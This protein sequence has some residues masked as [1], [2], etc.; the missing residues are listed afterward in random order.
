MNQRRFALIAPLSF[1]LALVGGAV[2]WT[3][4]AACGQEST[5]AEKE[6]AAAPT[7]TPPA[8]DTARVASGGAS[9][10]EAFF[11]PVPDLARK[12]DPDKIFPHGRI[13]P[14]GFYGLNLRRDKP[15]GLTLIG[16]YGR[17]QNVDTAK[18]LGLK[19]TYT[20]SLPM[21]FH[22]KEPLELTPEEIRRRIR[23]QVEAVAGHSEIAWWY[24]A[25]EELRYW[26]SNEMTYLEVAADAIRQADPLKRPVWMY[27]PGHYDAADLAHTVKHLDICGKGM[28][29]NY[30]D[31][32]DSRV[33]VRWTIEQEIEAVKRA[34][35]SAI[36]IAVPEMFQQPP[37]ELLPMIPK[38]VRHDVYLSLIAG[39]KGMVV[40]SG[41]RRP[42]FPAFD[43]YYQAYASC[44]REING[45][46][47]LGRVFLFGQK[48]HDVRIRVLA[49]PATVTTSHDE[50]VEY[51]SVAFLDV[52]YGR[53][54]YLFVANSANRPVRALVE[55]LPPVPIGIEDLFQPDRKTI[56]DEGKF[57]LS[58]ESLEVRAFRFEKLPKS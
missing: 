18:K 5:P 54:R 15:E 7:A 1:L 13:F 19:C 20:I 24:L 2:M 44:A 57:E 11:R 34:N 47:N 25:P 50:P 41:W 31:Q 56:A 37:E 12:Y 3:G 32:R 49:G 38:W 4:D 23:E 10:S 35:P 39:A 27:D 40:F 21:E 51:P 14:V 45:P 29:T 46:L 52:A 55:G 42:K 58:L 43:A 33:W 53:Q 9:G 8:E 17:Q 48:R 16:P 26:R 36:P 30:S 22:S 28:Y 6:A